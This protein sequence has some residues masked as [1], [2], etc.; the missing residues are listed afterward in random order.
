M[1]AN[2]D[3]ARVESEAGIIATLI[4]HPDFSYYSEQLL[5]NHFTNEEN[6]YIYQAICSLARDGIERIDP[7]NIIQALTAKEATR[8]FAD[9]LSI[10]QL[11]TL[12]ENSENISRNTVEEYKL[13][14]NNVMDA[15]FRRDTYQQL[16]ECQKLCTQP[17]A[18]NIEQKIYKMLD[19]VMMEFSTTNDVPAYKDVVDKCWEEIKGRQGAGYAG[20]P[21]KFPALNDYATIERGEL[22][23]FG[24]EQK[25]G[26]SMMLLNCAVDLLK[27]DYAV[28]YLDSE[29]NTRLFTSRILAHLSG[30]E[31]KRLTSGNYS[32]EEEQRILAA[33][34]WLK[35][36][37]F[38]HIYIPM[39]DQQSIYTAVNK[40]KHT[41]GLDV[42]IVDYFKGKGEGD[43][44]DSYQEL[45]RF[46][47][48]V[49]NQICGEMN[50]AGIG[51]AQATITGKLADSAKI[52]RNASTIAM[53]S[54]KTPEEI[55]ADGAECGNKKLRVT[56]N[57]NGIQER[58][59]E[60]RKDKGLNLE[61]LSKLTGISKSA[62]GS[63]EKEDFKEINHGNL[64]TLA[65]FYGVSVDYLLCRTENR[66]QI[67]T[68]L[69]ELHLNDE[70]VALLKSG[71]INNRLLCELATHKDFIKFLADIEIYV[72]GIA[73][74][75]IQNL[76]TL[77]DTVRHEIIE[78]YRP[79]EDDPHLKVLQAAHISDDE[80]FSHMVLDDLNLIIRD[81]RETHKKDS[82]SAP[83]TTVAN[84]LKENLEAVE[85]FKGSRLEKLAVLYC[86][87]LGINYKNLSDE[88]FRWLIRILKKSKK[89]GTPISQRKKR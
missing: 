56:V 30:I 13:L 67:N 11:Y 14:V 45:G 15:A 65:D 21:F 22:F 26:K 81:I 20:I 41:Q 2:E 38:T 52:A 50:I 27:Q 80:Y 1:L 36:R 16:K 57:R 47:D 46:V 10:D 88:E 23:I 33:K 55:E 28:L 43:A 72:D 89:M 9:E 31:Y 4:H 60:L 78:R 8:R 62:L 66:E 3:M 77:V 68:P 61:E 17:S 71:R 58:L 40:V 19:D 53:I 85:N 54:D 25:Q 12:M 24:A 42:L 37:K 87:Q 73:T 63:Y 6:R 29:L 86:K 82:E 48:M 70:M 79:G 59:W 44:F 74:M 39:F 64:I 83:Q 51:A 69:T 49:K 32:E 18:E 76:N 35:T 7:Y 34:E 75:Q 5:P 84:E